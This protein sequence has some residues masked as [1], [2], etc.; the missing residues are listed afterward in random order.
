MAVG[1]LAWHRPSVPLPWLPAK[2]W[3]QRVQLRLL[4]VT[5]P[6]WGPAQT[7]PWPGRQRAAGDASWGA[8][9]V[10]RARA[11]PAAR[12]QEEAAATFSPSSTPPFEQAAPRHAI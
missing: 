4:R 12:D 2:P 9:E 8:R 11:E 6:W 7:L 1:T 3:D 10:A 5:S